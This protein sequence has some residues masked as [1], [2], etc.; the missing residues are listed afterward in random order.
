M[1]ELPMTPSEA[2]KQVA[3]ITLAKSKMVEF[4]VPYQNRRPLPEGLDLDEQF[5][6]A[7]GILG[8]FAAQSN[9]IHLTSR[10][11]KRAI[12]KKELVFAAQ[13]LQAYQECYR[14][15]KNYTEILLLAASAYFLADLP[16]RSLVLT[17]KISIRTVPKSDYLLNGLRFMLE[18]P[19]DDTS[20]NL[21]ENLVRQLCHEIYSLY[22]GTKRKTDIKETCAK[23]VD[24]AYS[25]VND[26]NLLYADLLCAVALRRSENAAFNIL[27]R[28]SSTTEEAW[29]NYLSRP[30][31]V[32]ELWPSQHAL[33]LGGVYSGRSAVVQ[34]PTSTGKTRATEIIIRSAFMSGRAN[35]AVIIAPFRALCQEISIEL[36]RS[37]ADDNYRVNQLSDTV[38]ED[39]NSEVGDLL[40]NHYENTPIV[41]IATPEK[42]LY[43]LRRE[44]TLGQHVGLMIYDEGHQ[45]DSGVR[46]VTYE[47]LLTSIKSAISQ[48]AQIILISAVIENARDIAYWL[49]D[50]PNKV[51]I[52]RNLQSRRLVAFTEANP[53]TGVKLWFRNEENTTTFFDI[54]ILS[55]QISLNLRGRETTPRY[56]PEYNGPSIALYVAMTQASVGA[57]AIYCHSKASVSKIIR[58]FVEEIWPRNLHL[59][60]ISDYCDK[61]ELAA[62]VN[63][64]SANFGAE[65]VLMKGA[66]LGLFGHHA[67]TPRG[68]RNAIEHAMREGKIKLVI[69]T[70]TLAQG[71][72]LPIKYLFITNTS[73]GTD[74]LSPRDF[75]NLMGRAGRA[76]MHTEGMVIFTNPKLLADIH[77]YQGRRDWDATQQ[78]LE[79]LN[80][81]GI[82]ST[83]LN[84]LRPLENPILG[85]FYE[86]ISAYVIATTLAQHGEDG[87]KFL[88]NEILKNSDKRF[89]TNLLRQLETKWRTVQAI[90]SYLMTYRDTQDLDDYLHGENSLC[91]KT[92]AYF[93]SNDESKILLV[94]IFSLVSA[95][96][97]A[98]VPDFETQYRYGKTLLGLD[99]CLYIDSWVKSNSHS[100]INISSAEYMLDFLWPLL[101]HFAHRLFSNISNPTSLPNLAKSWINGKNFATMLSDL[102]GVTYSYGNQ[103][104]IFS[105]EKV[106]GICERSFSH[107]FCLTLS[108]VAD[109]LS[110]IIPRAWEPI[111]FAVLETLQRQMKYGLPNNSSLF[112][113]ETG[114]SDRVIAQ[115]LA[116]ICRNSVADKKNVADICKIF[117]T[118]IRNELQ[119]YPSFYITEFERLIS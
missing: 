44:P 83:L 3:E 116:I 61:K 10:F 94:N 92:L 30:E 113:Y 79:P 87:Y 85:V 2:A 28:L 75:H 60:P 90:E 93:L 114:F 41:I 21:G 47:L 107:E 58:E 55:E 33:G 80:V 16:G 37:F 91:E 74:E 101:S 29:T 42:F 81:A 32:K 100:L 34:M 11:P 70:S 27:P 52:D 51:I 72:N 46:G 15:S 82:G 78:L 71:V 53:A 62:L 96:I 35:F 84:L 119:K 59:A 106:V 73:Q 117:S 103:N 86:Q 20:L 98:A 108:A 95:R 104:R 24:L 49:I 64:Y 115:E 57:S 69:C 12:I 45:F 110:S 112:F 23:I 19:W 39:Y 67:N 36:T 5:P 48:E 25:Q 54:P 102:N 88:E 63:L 7:L 56:F 99:D 4:N 43:L 1:K 38:Q 65:S 40:Q 77:T 68:I 17:R 66:Q 111:C 22:R 105:L 18:R 14:T 6:L 13:V 8:D 89:A 50:D 31:A 118:E 9:R 76:G 26:H 97:D 109:S